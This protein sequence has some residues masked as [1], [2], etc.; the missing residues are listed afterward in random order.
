MENTSTREKSGR[1]LSLGGVGPG[2]T[3]QGLAP[4]PVAPVVSVQ[5]LA[6]AVSSLGQLCAVHSGWEHL[7]L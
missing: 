3:L 1:W 6:L 4:M 2:S 7:P 5:V